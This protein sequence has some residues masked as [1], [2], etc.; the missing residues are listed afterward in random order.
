[1]IASFS[2]I[3]SDESPPVISAHTT[4]L[5]AF[6]AGEVPGEYT[7]TRSG[8]VSRAGPVFY[9]FVGANGAGVDFHAPPGVINFAAGQTTATVPKFPSMTTSSSVT[10]WCS[11]S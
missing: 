5:F 9:Q 7:V 3:V 10:S 8:D 1:M 2:G 11:W 4:T 6:E